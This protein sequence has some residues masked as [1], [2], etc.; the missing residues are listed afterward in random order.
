MANGSRE[1][2]EKSTTLQRSASDDTCRGVRV[3]S[4]W[5]SAMVTSTGWVVAT[6]MASLKV[7]VTAV[8]VNPGAASKWALSPEVMA[9]WSSSSSRRIMLI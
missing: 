2:A 5:M 4:K 7:L 3:A 1:K 9:G 6:R 8:T